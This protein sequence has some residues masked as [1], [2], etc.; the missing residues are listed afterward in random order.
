[1]LTRC[2]RRRGGQRTRRVE[3]RR[4]AGAVQGARGRSAV[5][6]GSG[7]VQTCVVAVVGFGVAA[8]VRGG[9]R[10]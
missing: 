7:G 4:L 2:C 10:G 6:V 9:R 1:M 8:G 3:R 5:G